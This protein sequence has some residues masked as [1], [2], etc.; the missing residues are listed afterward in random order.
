MHLS[1][2]SRAHDCYIGSITKRWNVQNDCITFSVSKKHQ[3]IQNEITIFNRYIRKSKDNDEH[4]HKWF[5]FNYS[6]SFCEPV[7]MHNIKDWCGT[8][9]NLKNR[10]TVIHEGLRKKISIGL[11]I[12]KFLYIEGNYK[13]AEQQIKWKIQR[14]KWQVLN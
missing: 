13:I 7:M 9:N 14:N 1:N 12:S 6:V 3:Y 2:N 4:V 5:Q 11:G 10:I 8:L